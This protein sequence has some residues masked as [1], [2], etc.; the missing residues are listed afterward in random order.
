[1]PKMIGKEYEEVCRQNILKTAQQILDEAIDIGDGCS[2]LYK[3]LAVSEIYREKI[4]QEDYFFLLGLDDDIE[5]FPKGKAR[6]IYSTEA[7]KKF[8]EEEKEL[9][10]FHK[11]NIIKTCKNI[12]S[13]EIPNMGPPEDLYAWPSDEQ[14]RIWNNKIDQK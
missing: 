3:A 13:S 9:L 12:L 11:A 7:L 8:D 2:L 4:S 1:M 6:E 5:M 14:L 10:A